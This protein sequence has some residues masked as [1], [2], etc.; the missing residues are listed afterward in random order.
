MT[1]ASLEQN[2]K[3]V[4]TSTWL[5][6]LGRAFS[7]LL[8]QDSLWQAHGLMSSTWAEAV[9]AQAHRQSRGVHH[10]A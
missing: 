4:A 9:M 2:I 3:A 10:H 7:Q 6:A 8:P 1:E 5:L